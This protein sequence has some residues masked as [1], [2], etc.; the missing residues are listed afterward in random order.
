MKDML[1]WSLVITNNIVSTR[2]KIFL[3]MNKHG[4]GLEGSDINTIISH[5]MYKITIKAIAHYD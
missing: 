2:S 5:Y 4:G 1:R 3:D